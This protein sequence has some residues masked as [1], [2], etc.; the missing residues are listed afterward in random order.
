[1]ELASG[2]QIVGGLYIAKPLQEFTVRITTEPG[3]HMTYQALGQNSLAVL[4]TAL[5][6]YGITRIVVSPVLRRVK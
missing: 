5:E 3:V 4:E 2:R 1:M 6:L